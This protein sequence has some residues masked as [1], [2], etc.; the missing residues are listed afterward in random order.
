[1]K[2]L[3][4]FTLLSIIALAF[5]CPGGPQDDTVK[6]KGAKVTKNDGPTEDPPC[7]IPEN[8]NCVT[9]CQ[10]AA[11]NPSEFFLIFDVLSSYPDQVTIE[12][13]DVEIFDQEG[14]VKDKCSLSFEPSSVVYPEASKEEKLSY[15]PGIDFRFELGDRLL[16]ILSILDEDT[17][18]QDTS[19][20][21][22]CTIQ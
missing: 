20:L 21:T 4:A 16:F 13:M 14:E 9:V 18:K 17:L 7:N 2:A 22:V 3:K 8:S 15:C 6:V 10:D 19:V 11:I 1:M 12:T 5:G